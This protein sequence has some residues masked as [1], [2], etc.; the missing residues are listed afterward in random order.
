MANAIYGKVF[1][2]GYEPTGVFPNVD[3]HIAVITND[4]WTEAPIAM[5]TVVHVALEYADKLHDFQGRVTDA[6][7]AS[8]VIGADLS[9][10]IDI[11]FL[12]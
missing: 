8:S 6:I 2:L 9:G 12:V 4:D 5:S 7:Q 3:A 11:E 10:H 1:V